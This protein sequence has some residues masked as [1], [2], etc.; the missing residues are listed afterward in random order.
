MNRITE[1]IGLGGRDSRSSAR[2][3]LVVYII[4]ILSLF[5]SGSRLSYSPSPFRPQLTLHTTLPPSHPSQTTFTM[6]FTYNHDQL[7]AIESFDT[8]RLLDRDDFEDTESIEDPAAYP[9]VSAFV[10]RAGLGDPRGHMPVG[11]SRHFLQSLLIS[12]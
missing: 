11:L 8:P 6:S 12:L 7:E 10:L 3:L 4:S 2:G 9:N 5:F 1:M